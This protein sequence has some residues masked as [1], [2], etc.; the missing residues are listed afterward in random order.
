MI[1]RPP[2]STLFPYRRSS[3]LSSRLA[4]SVRS[5]DGGHFAGQNLQRD[6]FQN[7]LCSIAKTSV[8][9]FEYHDD[10][11]PPVFRSSDMKNGAPMMAVRMEMGISA[12][13]ALLAKVSTRSTK[14]A[15]TLIQVGTTSLLLLPRS[16]RETCGINSPTL[17]SRTIRLQRTTMAQGKYSTT[18]QV[19]IDDRSEERR[20]GKECRSRWS[21]YH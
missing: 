21:P 11:P 4:D 17:F 19:D 10:Q 16:I 7:F 13:V 5:E 8:Y 6:V 3:D 2:R 20:V 14:I 18:R 9:D 15:P 12:S 1:R